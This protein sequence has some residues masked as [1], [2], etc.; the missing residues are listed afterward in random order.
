MNASAEGAFWLAAIRRLQ[1]SLYSNVTSS[2]W[3]SVTCLS[4]LHVLTH[5]VAWVSFAAPTVVLFIFFGGRHTLG[6]SGRSMLCIPKFP[7]ASRCQDRPGTGKILSKSLVTSEWTRWLL[8]EHWSP[9]LC[10]IQG[11]L[12]GCF[13][14]TCPLPAL[15]LPFPVLPPSPLP[16]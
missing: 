9:F 10:L 14:F 3:S 2:G 1:V 6:F 13:L 11:G 16:L 12:S 5:T 15:P 8:K 4:Q 7:A